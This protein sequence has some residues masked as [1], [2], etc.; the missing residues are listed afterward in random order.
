MMGRLYKTCSVAGML[1]MKDWIA[2]VRQSRMSLLWPLL[3]P[4]AYT[5]LFVLLRPLVAGSS[6]EGRLQFAMFI[7]V[8]LSLWQAWYEALRT[9]ME[10]L[11]RHKG[12][13][14]R[15][16]IGVPTLALA[17]ALSTLL[18][19]AP[20]LVLALI[21]ITVILPAGPFDCVRLVLVAVLIVANGSAIGV[22]L[23]PFATLSADWAKALQSIALALMVTG[24]VFT[25]LPDQLPASVEALLIVNPLG[26]LLNL[27]RAPLFGEPVV[28][29]AA[30]A[31][32]SAVTLLLGLVTPY[33]GRRVL[34]I[35]VERMGGG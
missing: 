19:L 32:W 18:Q 27:A 29:P 13:I 4:L 17:V 35:V 12:L 16:E 10:A 8:G 30:A 14:S 15:G 9:Q 21:G 23:Q 28:S 24:A 20:R 7:F 22:L 31:I 34:P 6:Q 11:K 26:T 1:A 3:H 2:D 5:V 25:P 33:L